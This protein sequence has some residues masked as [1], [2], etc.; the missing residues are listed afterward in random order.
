[1]GSSLAVEV[2]HVQQTVCPDRDASRFLIHKVIGINAHRKRGLH[3]RPCKIVS[4]PLERQSGGLCNA[5][6]MPAARNGTAEGVYSSLLING[7]I[8]GMCKYNAGRADS[9]KRL[10]VLDYAGSDRSGRIISGTADY[11]S[12]GFKTRQLRSLCRDSSGDLGRFVYP[13]KEG[14]V[15]TKLVQ[16]F[17]RPAAVR[18]VKKLHSAR[19]GNLGCELAGKHKAYVILR[20]ENMPALLIILR[21]VVLYPHDLRCGES[22][23]SRVRCDLDH[24]VCADLI[25][26]LSD[27]LRGTLIAP[28]D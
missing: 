17:V 19:V 20:K 15:D 12:S 24:S 7:N 25:G 16:Y 9:S 18:N 22:G 10:A 21:L 23:N 1:M 8:G 3:F 28:D 13:G 14:L 27:F 2:R 26:D 11:R 4:E 5:H 6:Y